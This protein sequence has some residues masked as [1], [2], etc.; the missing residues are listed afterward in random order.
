MRTHIKVYLT[1]T[2]YEKLKEVVHQ[3][4]ATISSFM[5]KLMQQEL[6]NTIGEWDEYHPFEHDPSVVWLIPRERGEC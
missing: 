6:S 2:E 1:E 3:R 4:G 5:R